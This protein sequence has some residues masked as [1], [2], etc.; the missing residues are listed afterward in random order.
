MVRWPGGREDWVLAE[1]TGREPKQECPGYFPG[2]Y[3]LRTLADAEVSHRSYR[4]ED[5]QAHYGPWETMIL[6]AGSRCAAAAESIREPDP[7]RDPFPCTPFSVAPG[8]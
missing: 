4:W 1:I 8:R 3:A 6:P 2:G 7:A 5:G